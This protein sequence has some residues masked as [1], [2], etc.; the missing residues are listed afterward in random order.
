MQNS[1]EGSPLTDSFSKWIVKMPSSWALGKF[2]ASA[3]LHLLWEDAPGGGGPQESQSSQKQ[4]EVQ[5]MACIL[6]L[7]PREVGFGH[8]K[9]Q[10]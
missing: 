6:G 3:Q 1:Q 9:K 10:S 7:D 2:Q 4:L 8:A 5:T